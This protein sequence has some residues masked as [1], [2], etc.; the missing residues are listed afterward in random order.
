MVT[1]RAQWYPHHWALFY[2]FEI[3]HY[4]EGKF[5]MAKAIKKKNIRQSKKVF[6]SPFKI[7]WTR[8]NYLLLILG[9]VVLILGFYVM[10]IGEW[11][12]TASLVFSPII[13]VIA[14]ILIFPGINFL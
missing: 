8:K 14:Y 7:Y 2:I 10:S 9:F 5:D 13:L 11:N 12:S 3:D 4:V 6:T 1:S